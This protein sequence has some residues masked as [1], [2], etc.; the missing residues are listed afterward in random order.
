MLQSY[1]RFILAAA[2][3]RGP[4]QDGY[5]GFYLEIFVGGGGVALKFIVSDC[6]IVINTEPTHI[7]SNI[8]NEP[9]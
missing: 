3:D 5:P 1:V 4:V 2:L 7:F 6:K 8:Y 9:E